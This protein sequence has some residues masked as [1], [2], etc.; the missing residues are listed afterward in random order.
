MEPDCTL[1]TCCR[2]HFRNNGLS[3]D[4]CLGSISHFGIMYILYGTLEWWTKP[5]VKPMAKSTLQPE[6]QNGLWFLAFFIQHKQKEKFDQIYF[7]T[8][9]FIWHEGTGDCW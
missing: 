8:D 4:T 5:M 2:R 3:F 9:L 1:L 6:F 7:I